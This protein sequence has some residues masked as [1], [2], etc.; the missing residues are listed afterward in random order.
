MSAIQAPVAY[1]ER[2]GPAIPRRKSCRACAKAKRRCDLI[3]PVC[4][5][6]SQ[7]RLNCEYPLLL[8]A[9]RLPFSLGS[10][11]DFNT[12][13]ILQPVAT[14][15][16]YQQPPP[17]IPY[18]SVIPSSSYRKS[19]RTSKKLLSPPLSVK[20][21]FT[22]GMSSRLQITLDVLQNAH[23]TMVLENQTPW[24]HPLLYKNGLPRVMQDAYACCSLYMNRNA[25]NS[26]TV[27][28]IIENRV[29]ELLAADQSSDAWDCLARL[30]ALILHQTIRIF[31]DDASA[32]VAAEVTMPALRTT[33]T[34]FVENVSLEDTLLCISGLPIN[35]LIEDPSASSPDYWHNWI[36]EESARRT[37]FLS[38]LLIRIWEV[39]QH[40]NNQ[41]NIQT[42]KSQRTV[43]K[44]Q[45]T[46]DGRLGL[47][48]S[49]WYWYLSAHLWEAPTRY[50]F[51]LAYAEKNRFVIK[52]LDFSE[53]LALG[54]PEDVDLLGKM[55]LSAL[56]GN[57]ALQ[58]WCFERG[59]ETLTGPAS[60]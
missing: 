5:R 60:L 30:Q 49:W 4:S 33:L 38:Y 40:M 18:V 43:E 27:L 6:C 41:Q 16:L 22:S 35:R 47:S 7:R 59:G 15:T 26:K 23:R 24:C 36:F 39:S 29:A 31:D 25:T 32:L 42:A 34:H 54:Q 8:E 55:A 48:N 20:P 9:S 12:F 51:A 45:L 3:L 58:E 19:H 11:P 10:A 57:E 2:N 53:F 44:K 13:D 17:P 46:C 21:L 52:D 1:K 50:D 37:L 56:M 28:S 14:A